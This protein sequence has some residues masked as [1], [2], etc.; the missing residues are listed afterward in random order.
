[1]K[2]VIDIGNTRTKL[3]LFEG[4][5][6]FSESNID[7]CSL[8]IVQD[9]VANQVISAAIISSVKKDDSELL[10][11]SDYYNGLILC[12]ETSIPI[13]N[14]YKHPHTLGNDRLAA[15]VGAY[16]LFPKKNVLVF[17]AGTC[18]T[19][20]FITEKGEYIGGR[21]SPGIG[22]R[23]KALHTFTDRLP[24]LQ[25]EKTPSIIGD[26][27]NSCIVSGVQRGILDEVR[28]VIFDY[29]SQKNDT[30][31][32][33]TGGDCFFF[34]K[35]LKNSIFANPNLVMIGLNEILDFNE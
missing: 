13:K 10:S 35:E 5:D 18:L 4:K 1:M 12:E 7:E 31:A 28:S 33:V 15:V 11:I 34:E 14:Q 22:M 30:I 20:D 9:F 27:T 21:V 17:D 19:I 6:L 25:K 8:T 29:R 24:L 16:F 2:L 26:D 32:V 3:A 23:Y